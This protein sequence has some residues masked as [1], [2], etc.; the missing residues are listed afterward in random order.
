MHNSKIRYV[1]CIPFDFL[2]KFLI[3]TKSPILYCGMSSHFSLLCLEWSSFVFRAPSILACLNI[4]RWIIPE[5]EPRYCS[6]SCKMLLGGAN[7]GHIQN[8][9]SVVILGSANSETNWM[10]LLQ[11]EV[12]DPIPEC[13]LLKIYEYNLWWVYVKIIIFC[14]VVGGKG[15]YNSFLCQV[16]GRGIQ[17]I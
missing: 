12:I 17:L 7:K 4:S 11:R 13:H 6:L 3:M 9:K 1:L 15:T 5:S 2:S 10:Q 16:A 14:W 8:V